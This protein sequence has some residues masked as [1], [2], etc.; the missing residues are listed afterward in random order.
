MLRTTRPGSDSLLKHG[1]L[2]IALGTA[3][4][5]LGSLMA[6]PI[7]QQL[8]YVL[9]AIFLGAGLL[10]ALLVPGHRVMRG[11]PR[12]VTAAYVAI[13]LLMVCYVAFSAI[14]GGSL[15]MPVVGLLAGLLALYWASRYITLACSFQAYS[16]QAIG[17][18]ALA[19]ANSSFGVILATRI[20]LS[21]LGIVT[22]AGCY[23]II[24]G[25]QI[26]LTAVAL[27]REVMREGTIE[28]R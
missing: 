9:A 27:H 18:S 20:G 23:I 2:M 15:E 17:L 3:V 4:C 5:G 25:V 8:G 10:F 28:R 21:K 14:Q 13:G 6:K 16:P 1:V 22:L 26:Y 11:L 19:A 24:L 7:H 12:L